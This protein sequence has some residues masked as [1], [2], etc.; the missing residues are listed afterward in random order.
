VYLRLRLLNPLAAVLA[1]ALLLAG[2]GGGGSD[3]SERIV[4][5]PGFVFAAPE[6]WRATRT[7]RL[8]SASPEAGA[9][10]LVS[11][12]VFPL[13]RRFR[14]ALWPRVV[15]ELDRVAGQLARGLDGEVVSSKSGRLGGLPARQYE[16]SYT[17]MDRDLRQRVAF[18]LRGRTEYQLLCRWEESDGEPDACGLLFESF[19]PAL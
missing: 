5:G 10:E 1:A 13:Q 12:S 16:I 4:Q 14:P 7:E 6:S 9:E 17:R 19:R 15:G 8:A 2:C 18:A 11:V 3:G